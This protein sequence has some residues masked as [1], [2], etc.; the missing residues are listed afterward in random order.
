MN[1]RTGLSIE[2]DAL[3]GNEKK[4]IEAISF[5]SRALTYSVDY[6]ERYPYIKFHLLISHANKILKAK[7]KAM[8]KK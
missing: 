8:S 4:W 2:S 3:G 6:V 7:E 1:K 5:V